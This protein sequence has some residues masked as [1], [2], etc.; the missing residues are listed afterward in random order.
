LTA[1]TQN[2][3]AIIAGTASGLSATDARLNADIPAAIDLSGPK[4]AMDTQAPVSGTLT[5]R[6]EIKSLWQLLG[7]EQHTLAGQAVIDLKV[8]GNMD[9]PVITGGLRLTKGLYENL[10]AGTALHNIDLNVAARSGSLV[11]VT[12][13][14][15]D[16]GSGT[17]SASGSLRRG[18]DVPGWSVDMAGDLKQ[19]YVLRRDDVTAAASGH[20]TYKGPA[21]AGTIGGDLQIVKSEYRLGESYQPD[22]PILRG[23]PPDA[24]KAVESPIRLNVTLS[25]PEVLRTE[26][27][28]LEAFWRGDIKATGDIAHPDLVGQL[29]LA[30]G[31][32]SFLGKTFDLESGTVTFTGGGQINPELNIVATRQAEEITATVTITGRATEPQIT[33]SS[34]PALPQDEVLARLLFRRGTTQ[35]GPIE[36]LQLAN[37]A[38]DLSGISRGGLSGVLRRAS[39]LDIVGF[40][41]E[42]GNAIV[43]GRQFSSA[44]YVGIEQNVNDSTRRIVIEWRLTRQFSLQ[45]TTTGE[46]GADLGVL[47]RKNY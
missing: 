18:G 12:L 43:L 3:R 28:G 40:G 36:S 7:N 6:G 16:T 41:G 39:G 35:L 8:A 26:G 32:F 23:P 29:T 15:T 25:V 20:F 38:A 31:T 2:G 10:A 5:W 4:L 33:L 37:A 42:S 11:D 22:I 30:R 1:H 27:Q 19:F 9:E 44:L 34:Q 13:A 45:S 14:A 17:L 24:K 21:L 47:W 46:A